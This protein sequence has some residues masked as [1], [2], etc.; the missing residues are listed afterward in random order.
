[1]R[2]TWGGIEKPVEG[3]A[4]VAV[5]R[6]ERMEPGIHRLSRSE[7]AFK[8]KAGCQGKEPGVKERTGLQE[9]WPP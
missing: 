9:H 2:W 1:M 7:P 8:E 6:E 5:E 4:R 3:H